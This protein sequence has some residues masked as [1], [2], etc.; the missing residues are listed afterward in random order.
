MTIQI[1]LINV[2]KGGF[3][4]QGEEI[5]EKRL[6]RVE[7]KIEKIVKNVNPFSDYKPGHPFS[8]RRAAS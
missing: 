3:A 5:M 2:E 4:K 6:R 8:E 7:N 1:V